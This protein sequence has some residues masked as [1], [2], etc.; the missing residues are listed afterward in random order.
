MGVGDEHGKCQAA[1]AFP[2]SMCRLCVA[3]F[4]DDFV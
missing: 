3:F 1:G 4:V 2:A